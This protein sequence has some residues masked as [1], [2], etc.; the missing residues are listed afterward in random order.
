MAWRDYAFGVLFGLMA[1]GDDDDADPQDRDAMVESRDAG[2]D[3]RV[4]PDARIDARDASEASVPADARVADSSVPDASVPRASWLIAPGDKVFFVGNSF[5]NSQDRRLPEWVEAIGQAVEPKFPIETGEH[6]VPG[7]QPLSWF[8]EQPESQEAIASGNYDV[9][10]V[11]GEEEEPVEDK[12]GFHDAV[13]A[14]HQAITAKGGRMMLFMTWNFPWYGGPDSEWFGKLSSAYE[15]IGQELNIPVIP[16]GVIYNDV[17]KA[18]F[19]GQDPWFLTN[20]DLHQVASGSA[21]NAYAT[22]SMLTGIDAM[23][24]EFEARN[25]DNTPE[26]LRYCSEKSWLRVSEKLRE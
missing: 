5:F 8:F 3:A 17:V 13:R 16:V 4:G 12:E 21:I 6:N 2:A 14:Y 1:C 25:N 18:P 15:E 23:G 24:V 9:F 19:P 26:M 20:H 10:I 11:Q 7:V 22:F